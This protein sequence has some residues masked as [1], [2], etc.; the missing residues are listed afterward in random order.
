MKTL[1]LITVAMLVGCSNMS[2]YRAESIA[3]KSYEIG[4]VDRGSGSPTDNLRCHMA[5][6]KF[7]N[8]LHNS[9]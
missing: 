6:Q 3:Q 2:K 5:S 4:C 9:W 7:Q 8:E 1:L